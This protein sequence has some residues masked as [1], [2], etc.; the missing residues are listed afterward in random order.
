MKSLKKEVDTA[1]LELGHLLITKDGYLLL[2]GNEWIAR[3]SLQA[4]TKATNKE[5]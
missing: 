1:N 3:N 4:V 2:Q 5:G